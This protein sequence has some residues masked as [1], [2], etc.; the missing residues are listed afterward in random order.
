MKRDHRRPSLGGV[1]CDELLEDQ[2]GSNGPLRDDEEERTQGAASPREEPDPASLEC[3]RLDEWWVGGWNLTVSAASS[4]FVKQIFKG[5]PLSGR[6]FIFVV[7]VVG[8]VLHLSL[9]LYM[10]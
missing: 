3:A 9:R 1:I 4:L 8:N 7:V 2:S 6:M 10:T 5:I